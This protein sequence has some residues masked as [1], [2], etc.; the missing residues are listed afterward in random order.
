MRQSD[1][2]GQPAL[3]QASFFVYRDESELEA[4]KG[5]LLIG[6][7]FVTQKALSRVE[8]N[9]GYHCGQENYTGEIHFCKLPKNFGGEFSA[10]ARVARRWMRAYQ[11][12]LCQDALFTCLAANHASPKFERKRFKQDYHAYNRFTA[13]AIK[14]GILYLLAPLGYDEITLTV[15]SDGKDR[16]SRPEQN[17]VDNFEDYLAYRVELDNVLSQ[18][19][20]KR[21]YPTV[22]MNP[23]QTI[24]SEMN[25]LLQLRS[26]I[27]FSKNRCRQRYDATRRLAGLQKR[28]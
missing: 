17:L 8:E 19:Q 14:S 6:L 26:V 3:K 11:D 2:F 10:K 25:N 24:D 27:H 13:M 20:N 15:V 28:R 18:V 1:L 22:R 23:V 9:L 4:N 16:E 12:G 5:W 7:L 21:P